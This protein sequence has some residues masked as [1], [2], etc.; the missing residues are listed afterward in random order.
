MAYEALQ[1]SGRKKLMQTKM[2]DICDI[3]MTDDRKEGGMGDIK[4]L[5]ANI[6]KFGQIN[7]I[8]VYYT[9][10]SKKYFLIA[11]RRRVAAMQELGE[12]QIRADI[13]DEEEVGDADGI[14]LSENAVRA[15]MH[16]LDEAVY[17]DRMLS[18]GESIDDVAATF[19]RTKAQ[20]YQRSKLVKLEPE[21]RDLF[22]RGGLTVSEAAT[23]AE[24]PKK[25][26]KS[27]IKELQED[28][29]N[30]D[31]DDD[32]DYKP[33]S[34]ILESAIRN[35]CRSEIGERFMSEKCDGCL[36]RTHCNDASLFPEACIEKDYCLDAKCYKKMWQK[37]LDD[38]FKELDP[39]DQDIIVCWNGD[40]FPD[41][42]DGYV[43]IAGKKLRRKGTN[44]VTPLKYAD[45]DE[46]A[47]WRG[48]GIVHTGYFYTNEILTVQEFVYTE[49]VRTL[50]GDEDEDD[51]DPDDKSLLR[52]LPE[53]QRNKTM[54]E[55]N[56]SAW[57]IK[58]DAKAYIFEEIEAVAERQNVNFDKLLILSAAATGYRQFECSPA[59][60]SLRDLLSDGD[61]TN[62]SI[63]NLP[64]DNMLRRLLIERIR[65]E[66]AITDDGHCNTY[67]QEFLDAMNAAIDSINNKGGNKIER[68]DF[69]KLLAESV[70]RNI[71]KYSED[72]DDSEEDDDDAGDE[73]DE[74]EDDDSEEDDDDEKTETALDVMKKHS[75]KK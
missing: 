40:E 45:E 11:G 49:D 57:Q 33:E 30:S 16:P 56:Y 48:Q 15:E 72:E 64:G 68:V 34:W 20:V 42:T 21:L 74:G 10:G 73:S 53:D 69:E 12:S 6:K 2:I 36:K 28:E 47:G 8:K 71:D 26:Q 1:G 67:L 3:D 59:E 14:S 41:A 39:A 54:A 44:D 13:Y 62:S 27:V 46:I 43:T 7:P 65:N 37:S 61:Q 58:N 51:E 25:E 38:Q 63:G 9:A 66:S 29:K 5:A 32:G 35:A 31:D 18:A 70:K 22:K 50:E 23:L 19:C 24:L 60:E 52:S 55:N 17:F 75:G 4:G